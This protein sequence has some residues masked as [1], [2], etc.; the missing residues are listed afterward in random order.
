MGIWAVGQQRAKQ[1]TT[2]KGTCCQT[3]L[4]GQA[5]TSNS[6]GVAALQR[7]TVVAL[8]C[9]SGVTLWRC[10]N[11][12]WQATTT[13]AGGWRPGAQHWVDSL[14]PGHCHTG[15]KDG[16]APKD[17]VIY[18]YLHC[19]VAAMAATPCPPRRAPPPHSPWL[20]WGLTPATPR[21]RAQLS[22]GTW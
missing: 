7:C 6:C 8:W 12:S 16:G 3:P 1:N 22:Q 17:P 20:P 2:G 13:H 9:C 11:T 19:V 18:R 10:S 21:V 15:P 4:A 14:W 5:T